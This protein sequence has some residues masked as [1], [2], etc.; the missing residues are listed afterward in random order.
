MRLILTAA[1][2]CLLMPVGAGAQH[3]RTYSWVDEDGVKHYGDS[4]PPE[5]A[6]APKEVLNEHGVPVDHLQ[7]KKTQ[8]QLDAEERAAELEMQKELQRRADQALLS[9]YVNVDEIEMHRDRR[10]ELFQAQAR[11]TELYLRNLRKRLEQLRNDAMRYKPYSSDPDAAEIDPSLV[12]DIRETQVAIE[13]H[14]ENLKRYRSEEE[15]IRKRFEGDINRFMVLKG[16]TV[17]SAQAVPE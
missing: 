12:D 11:V 9:T 15:D 10:L 6:D 13:R 14:E 16:L 4:V 5:Y 2:L 1:A 17:T 3:T 8:E 7:G